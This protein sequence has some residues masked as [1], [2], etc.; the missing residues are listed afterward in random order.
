MILER[1]C[2]RREEPPGPPYTI[3]RSILLKGLVYSFGASVGIGKCGGVC[4][5]LL[6]RIYS[7]WRR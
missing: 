3:R 1:M 2:R 4:P 7:R 6:K 5:T